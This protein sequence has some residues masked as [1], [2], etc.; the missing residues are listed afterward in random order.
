MLRPL[1]QSLPKWKNSGKK[2]KGGF[3]NSKAV[4]WVAELEG[5]V[6]VFII[7]FALTYLFFS[8]GK[9]LRD[10]DMNLG[11]PSGRGMGRGFG[12]PGDMMKRR[13]VGGDFG[14]RPMMALEP[15]EPVKVLKQTVH[16]SE[17][18]HLFG[19]QRKLSSSVVALQP[20]PV[21]TLAA[22]MTGCEK[23]APSLNPDK[24]SVKRNKVMFGRLLGTLQ[25]A[26]TDLKKESESDKVTTLL[27]EAQPQPE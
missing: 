10:D 15:A 3:V 23:P 18:S 26:Q 27:P 11:S 12:L 19:V 9:R 13:A 24:S 4:E 6:D 14:G 20:Q 25:R 7:L 2:W 5:K 8:R 22:G 16:Y 1:E 21:P 17:F